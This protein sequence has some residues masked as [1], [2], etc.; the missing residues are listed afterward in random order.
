MSPTLSPP[1]PSSSHE[2]SCCV[3]A[4]PQ[5]SSIPYGS[6]TQPSTSCRLFAPCAISHVCRQR[7]RVRAA[8][9]RLRLSR[10]EVEQRTGHLRR[11]RMPLTQSSSA[12]MSS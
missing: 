6:N 2:A 3:V 7:S 10:L 1:R 5:L 9:P 12:L 4:G 8:V 11:L